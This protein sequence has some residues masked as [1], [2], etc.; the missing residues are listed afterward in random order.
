MLLEYIPYVQHFAAWYNNRVNT[1]SWFKQGRKTIKDGGKSKISCH[2]P[3]GILEKVIF[4]HA[5][6]E[7]AYGVKGFKIIINL[8]YHFQEQEQRDVI[9]Q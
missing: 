9:V 1:Q 3:D 6:W 7:T 8:C 2:L 5:V 4:N